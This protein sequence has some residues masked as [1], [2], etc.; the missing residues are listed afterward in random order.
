[1]PQVR[2]R[3]YSSPLTTDFM[4]DL[5]EVCGTGV[6]VIGIMIQEGYTHSSASLQ[7]N[8]STGVA[9]QLVINRWGSSQ[10]HVGDWFQAVRFLKKKKNKTHQNQTKAATKNPPKIPKHTKKP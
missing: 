9:W 10:T 8:A 1:M 5:D 2:N 7:T 4:V 3:R 6:D